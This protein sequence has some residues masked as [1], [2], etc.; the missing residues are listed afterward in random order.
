ML[1]TLS[2]QLPRI[3]RGGHIQTV[4]ISPIKHVSHCSD[5]THEP[6]DCL[7]STQL[8]SLK[9]ISK[10]KSPGASKC[11]MSSTPF[12]ANHIILKTRA[13]IHEGS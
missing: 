13:G 2:G 1:Q 7:Y 4:S 12:A 10:V 11:R 3:L 9:F 5:S 8:Q 6:I